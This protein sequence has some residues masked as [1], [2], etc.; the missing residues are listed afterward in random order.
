M[1]LVS[2]LLFVLILALPAVP[3]MFEV[4]KPKDDG[5]LHI[6]EQY[7]RDPR[8][9]GRSF[10]HK[11]APF[12]TEARG[13]S[14]GRAEL[15]MRTDEQ[16][17]WSPDLKIPALERLRGIG[18]G[19]RVVVGHGAGIRDAYALEHLDVEHDVVARTLTSDATMHIGSTVQVLRWID[20]D[21]DID[22]D[23]DSDLGLS[24][25]GGA[26]V[27]LGERVRFERVWGAPV[28]SHTSHREPFK[29][30][31]AAKETVVDADKIGNHHSLVLY[32]P[33]RVAAGTTIPAHLKVHGPVVI[34]PGVHI[35]GN[36]ISRG[37]VTLAEEVTIGGHI[38]AEGDIRLGPRSRVSR[39]TVAK[40]VYATGAVLIANDVEVFGWV[41]SENGGH[42]L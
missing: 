17:R 26:R 11:L 34:E 23:S 36:L 28:A 10:R 37:D 22:V 13:N 24:A 30:H 16:V 4:H 9:F 8:F 38:F 21:G 29:L 3:S 31:Q 39:E 1:L 19:E 20:A 27:T 18:V 42:T 33:V 15:Q 35:G 7:V 25:S 14:Y 40:T 32:G 5:R 41:V 2:L 12:V 6:M